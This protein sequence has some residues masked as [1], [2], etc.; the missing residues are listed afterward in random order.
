ML[1]HTNKFE[2]SSNR[3]YLEH[4]PTPEYHW[5][6]RSYCGAQKRMD[7]ELSFL[8]YQRHYHISINF[9]QRNT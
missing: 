6:R 4:H 7:T 8:Q 3:F 2:I 5:I 9:M 1:Q